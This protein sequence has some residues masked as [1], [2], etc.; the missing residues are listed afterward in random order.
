MKAILCL[1][2]AVPTLAADLSGYGRVTLTRSADTLTFTCADEAHADRLLSKLRADLTWDKLLGVR[3]VTLPGGAPA[4]SLAGG[5]SL[6]LARR[7][8][9]VYALGGDAP[10]AALRALKLG[11][12]DTAYVAAKRHPLSLDFFDLRA[13]SLYYLPMNVRDMAEGWH[14]YGRAELAALPDFWAKFGYGYSMFQPYFGCDELVDGA[15]HFFPVDYCTKQATDRDDIVMAHFGQYWAPWW[16]RNHYPADVVGWDPLALTGWGGI[17]AM[18]STHLSNFAQPAAAAYARRF[19]AAALDRLHADAGDNL[20]CIRSV[21]GG[22]PGDEMGFHHQS[23]EFM[24]YDEAGQAAFRRWLRDDRK[25]DLRALG[26]RWHGDAAH[27]KSWSEVTIPSN[28]EFFGAFGDGSLDLR[29][30]WLWRPD[31][32][33]AEDE[34]WPKTDYTPGDEWTPTDLAPSQRQLLLFGSRRDKELRDGSSTVAWFRKTFDPSVWLAAAP[35]A[36]PG[37]KPG[38]NAYLVAQVGDTQTQP[39]EVWL[40]DAYLGQIKPKTVW[41]GPIAF[42]ATT[43]LKPGRNVLVMKVRSGII[44]GPVFLTRTEPKRYPYLGEQ[45][46]ARYLDLRDWE[47][48]KLIQGWRVEAE[49]VRRRD[50]DTPLMFCP[51]G[52][53]EYW[54]RFL[55][56]KQDLG[57]NCLHFTGGGSSYMPWWSG[58]GYVWG[59]YGTSEEGGTIFEPEGLSRELAWMLLDATGHH[60]YYYDALDCKRIEDKTHW[61]SDHARLLDLLGK[62]TWARPPIAVFRAACSDNYFP[63]SALAD[64]WDIGR[65]S[66]QAAHYQNV[67]VTEAELKAG[68]ANDYP[69]VFDSGTMVMDDDLLAAIE[70]YVRAGGTFVATNVTGRHGRL[71]PDSWPMERLSGFKVLGERSDMHVTVLPDNPLLPHLAG[72]TFN[73][74]GI[75]VN[76]MGVNHLNEGAVALQPADGDGAVLAKWEDGTAAV[77]MRRLGK[78]RVIVLGSSFWRSMSDRAGNGVSLNG[79]VQTRFFDDLF[80]ALGLHRQAD[81]DSE[82]VWTR[83]LIT[84]N[85]L[86]D[87]VMAYNTGRGPVK[88]RTLSF[89]LDKRPEAVRDVVSGQSVPFAWEGGVVRV[90]GL[91]LAPNDVRVFGVARGGFVNAIEHWF[92]EKQRY[93]TRPRLPDTSVVQASGLPMS[94]GQ[95][96][97]PQT[98]STVAFEHFRFRPADPSVKTDLAWLGESTAAWKEVGYGFWDEQGFPAKGIGLYRADF[99]APAAWRGRRVML[100]C[101]SWDYPVFLEKATFFL[102]GQKVGDYNG[103]AWANFDEVDISAALRDGANALAVLVEA[104]EGRGGYIGELAAFALDDLGEA[105]DLNDNWRV[106]RDNQHAT[107]ATLPLDATGRYAAVDVDVPASWQGKNPVFEFEVA[108]RWVSCLVV[109][110]RAVAYNGFLHPYGNLMQVS[111]YPFIQPGATNRIELWSRS[112][113]GIAEQ[114]MVVKHARLGTLPLPVRPEEPRS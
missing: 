7:G 52:S 106:Y 89:P 87:W 57:I 101:A 73:G 48:T 14:R 88:G 104:T 68:L 96:P 109:N 113:N 62:A 63:Y 37:A 13:V 85:G 50:A 80:A 30:D 70:R 66:L 111:L 53:R 21:G 58:L 40:N 28:Y 32:A 77:G 39:V 65:S 24:D 93:E 103:H 107:P 23:T 90:A 76:W 43:L 4:L 71:T 25:L 33:A 59:A 54:D 16:L 110:G 29:Q 102:N 15:P 3:D 64:D 34:G 99:T 91:D 35:S 17:E 112:P 56:L 84:K 19:T 94:A 1:L 100:T 45:A 49:F 55:A 46:N 6:V 8:A 10:E 2:L 82:D 61:F 36:K 11:G 83:R 78:G 108:D 22:H 67:Y 9:S 51:G 38:A 74:N 47:A 60:N 95:R 114:K 81:I 105:R 92:G 42:N 86:E 20:G 27:S 97:A 26:R 98:T 44:R 12:P 72:L 41:A 79:S 18:G 5:G 31:K 69:V 75:A